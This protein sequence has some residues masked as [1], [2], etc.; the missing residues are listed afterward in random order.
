MS[1]MLLLL[2]VY[3]TS[4]HCQVRTVLSKIGFDAEMH[5]QDLLDISK[6]LF[7][8]FFQLNARLEDYIH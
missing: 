2:E 1:R 6:I 7:H 5:F 3:V 4:R 8:T